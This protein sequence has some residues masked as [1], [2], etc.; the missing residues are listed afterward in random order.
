MKFE[1]WLSNI[2]QTLHV[3]LRDGIVPETFFILLDRLSNDDTM[4]DHEK[5]NKRSK[6]DQMKADLSD[7][8]WNQS[9]DASFEFSFLTTPL[10]AGEL[11]D[12]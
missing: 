3:R 11:P 8:V 5:E 6:F 2:E 10:K 12:V 1:W 7:E 9:L 4:S